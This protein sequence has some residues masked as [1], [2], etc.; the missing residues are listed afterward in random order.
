LEP[1]GRSRLA[2]QS[3]RR[4]DTAQGQGDAGKPIIGFSTITAMKVGKSA[5]NCIEAVSKE[6]RHV[7]AERDRNVGKGRRFNG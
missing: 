3:H 6:H 7:T 4:E 5:I 2:G 1:Q